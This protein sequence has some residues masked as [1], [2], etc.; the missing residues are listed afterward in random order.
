M[1]SCPH[2]TYEETKARR[3]KVACPRLS[4]SA[5]GRVSPGL[6]RADLENTEA[7]CF[8]LHWVSSH[9]PA[10]HT[11]TLVP[12]HLQKLGHPARP[13]I[14]REGSLQGQKLREH[15]GPDRGEGQS[16]GNFWSATS[17]QGEKKTQLVF[18]DELLKLNKQRTPPKHTQLWKTSLVINQIHPGTESNVWSYV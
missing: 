13:G 15:G 2:F 9:V 16:P 18:P 6:E 7:I 17:L 4:V 14:Q 12:G 10:A 5:G 11:Q 1:G 8:L 3:S